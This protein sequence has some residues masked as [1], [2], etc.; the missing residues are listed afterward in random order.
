MLQGSVGKF[1]ETAMNEQWDQGILPL[2][3]ITIPWR[4]AEFACHVPRWIYI[5]YRS[6]D[7]M[8]CRTG[9]IFGICPPVTGILCPPQSQRMHVWHTSLLVYHKNQLNVGKYTVR[10]MDPLSGMD[11]FGAK[12]IE[13]DRVVFFSR[14]RNPFACARLKLRDRGGPKNKMVNHFLSRRA[15]VIVV[16]SS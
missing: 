16:A 12:R 10:P 11:K 2:A 14:G 13:Y 5:L 3:I 7:L 15:V 9:R 1:L 6:W 8:R 4:R